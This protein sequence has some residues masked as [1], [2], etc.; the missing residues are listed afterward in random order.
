MLGERQFFRLLEEFVCDS[1]V[2]YESHIV[3][4]LLQ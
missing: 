4:T 2:E 3:V 1:Y